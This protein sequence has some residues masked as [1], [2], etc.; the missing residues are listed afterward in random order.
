MIIKNILCA[1]FLALIS[2]AVSAEDVYLES[3]E[4]RTGEDCVRVLAEFNWVCDEFESPAW[5]RSYER[6]FWGG[7]MAPL[8]ASR[9]DIDGDGTEDV[10]LKILF[11]G[12]CSR[13][14]NF[15]C[16]HYFFVRGSTPN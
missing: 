12:R 15:H 14:G 5:V 7:A 4:I 13:G 11:S 16:S 9:Y 3:V 10:M 2:T 1:T 8:I 6:P